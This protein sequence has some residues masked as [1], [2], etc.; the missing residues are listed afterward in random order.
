M[1]TQ[2]SDSCSMYSEVVF[3]SQ[4]FVV[5]LNVSLLDLQNIQRDAW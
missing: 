3:V 5:S 1:S 4:R 2:I